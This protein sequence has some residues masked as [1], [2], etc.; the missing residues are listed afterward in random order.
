MQDESGQGLSPGQVGASGHWDCDCP[1]RGLEQIQGTWVWAL[2][3]WNWGNGPCPMVAHPKATGNL[4]HPPLSHLEC[5]F[6]RRSAESTG[7]TL[8]TCAWCHETSYL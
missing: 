6:L 4:T 2:L 7:Y 5:F 8:S 3:R 1:G